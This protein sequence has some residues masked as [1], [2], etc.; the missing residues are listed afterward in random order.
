MSRSEVA[1]EMRP[2]FN[3]DRGQILNI[4]DEQIGSVSRIESRAGAVRADHYH[5][6]D[7]HYCLLE[8]GEVNYFHRPV[9][10]LALPEH[11][12]FGVG[13]L[14]YTPPMFEHTMVF[15]KDSVMWCFAKNPRFS[16]NYEA[17]T[18]RIPTLAPHQ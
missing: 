18:V 12:T 6:T 10:S 14:F 3:D 17:D 15:T 5:K 8:S 11:F 9:G 13:E 7:W 1:T 16:A 4:L 2:P